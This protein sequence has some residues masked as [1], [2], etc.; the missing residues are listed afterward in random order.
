[1]N[2]SL[3]RRVLLTR[4]RG[5]HY[6]MGCRLSRMQRNIQTAMS[7]LIL[8]CGVC[9]GFINM[10]VFIFTRFIAGLGIG[11]LYPIFLCMFP[12]SSAPRTAR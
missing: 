4:F 6:F 10:A 2:T 8:G 11:M 7:V 5:W 1:M 12:A 3:S 9:V